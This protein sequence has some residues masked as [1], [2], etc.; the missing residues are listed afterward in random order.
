MKNTTEVGELKT[1]NDKI[2]RGENEIVEKQQ[3]RIDNEQLRK[4]LEGIKLVGSDMPQLKDDYKLEDFTP[5]TD[6]DGYCEWEYDEQ[7]LWDC[8]EFAH[9]RIM[10][11]IYVICTTGLTS[12]ASIYRCLKD[13]KD[14]A[15]YIEDLYEDLPYTSAKETEKRF[16][17]NYQKAMEEYLCSGKEIHK[18]RAIFY[19]TMYK[20]CERVVLLEDIL[21]ET[22]EVYTIEELLFEIIAE[23]SKTI[24]CI[25]LD[26]NLEDILIKRFNKTTL[27]KWLVNLEEV[28]KMI[29]ESEER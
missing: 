25:F 17:R 19:A 12:I 1:Q 7:G 18:E 6:E 23:L 3:E 8:R 24:G 16:Y 20:L 5:K 14:F 10:N 15:G 4:H 28:N 13:L 11:M 22:V 2:E 21:G 29:E 27:V 26:E 9:E